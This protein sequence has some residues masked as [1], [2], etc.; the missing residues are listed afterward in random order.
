MRVTVWK[1]DKE[2]NERCITRFN[3]KVQ[4]SRILQLLRGK[5]FHARSKTRRQVREGAVKREHYRKIK[6]KTKFY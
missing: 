1:N 6:E 2:S 5:R 4:A 3:K